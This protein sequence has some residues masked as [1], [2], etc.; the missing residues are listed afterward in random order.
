MK[1]CKSAL[2]PL[3]SPLGEGKVQSFELSLFWFY[4]FEWN[5]RIMG[6]SEDITEL[7]LMSGFPLHSMFGEL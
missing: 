3:C 2:T 6:F 1:T 5:M 7:I 4:N